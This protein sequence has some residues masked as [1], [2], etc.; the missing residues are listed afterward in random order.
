MTG[1]HLQIVFNADGRKRKDG[2][3]FG[4]F[5]TTS[6]Q[7]ASIDFQADHSISDLQN[8]IVLVSLESYRN[9]TRWARSC[10][11]LWTHKLKRGKASFRILRQ[12]Y[13]ALSRYGWILKTVPVFA[14]DVNILLLMCT[15]KQFDQFDWIESGETFTA[16]G[17][18][19]LCKCLAHCI[20]F[21][22][23]THA[24]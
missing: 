20:E 4:F 18:L 9:E 22:A 21:A 23:W 8:K 10:I 7:E 17:S 12:C 13:S 15:A 11:R 16:T 5:K 14:S 1:A 6:P 3:M 2:A 19:R 24:R